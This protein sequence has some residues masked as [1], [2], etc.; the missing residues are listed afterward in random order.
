MNTPH[1]NQEI[2]ALLASLNAEFGKGKGKTKREP[3]DI[4]IAQA[5]NKDF[6]A[7][8]KPLDSSAVTARAN[9]ED[10]SLWRPVAKVTYVHVQECACCSNTTDYTG[11][12][13]IKFQSVFG[14]N[15]GTILR[16]ATHCPSLFL[17]DD[18]E[19]P[20]EDLIEWHFEMVARCPGCIK[21]EQQAQAVLWNEHLKQQAKALLEKPVL[22]LDKPLPRTIEEALVEVLKPSERETQ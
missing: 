2:S 17:I 5:R 11:S 1:P 19:K 6:H 10:S 13:Y 16:K 22:D 7:K 3:T 14:M 15:G 4:E 9:P 21:V 8:N 12:E 20:L 18:L